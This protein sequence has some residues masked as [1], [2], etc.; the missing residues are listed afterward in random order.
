VRTKLQLKLPIILGAGFFCGHSLLVIGLW[1]A[2]LKN[3]EFGVLWEHMRLTDMPVSMFLDKFYD[4]YWKIL[5][6]G[7]YPK[8]EV[9]FHLILGGLQ[10]FVWGLLLGALAKRFLLSRHPP[11]AV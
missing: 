4:A 6:Q 2:S 10:F 11:Q 3:I 8:P 5:P 7:S 9:L 1:R